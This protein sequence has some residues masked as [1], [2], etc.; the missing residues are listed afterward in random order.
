MY[1]YYYYLFFSPPS[2]V[3]LHANR[4]TIYLCQIFFFLYTPKIP[5]EYNVYFV[6]LSSV[7]S[8]YLVPIHVIIYI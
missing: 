2:T 6:R 3:D 4:Q 8:P 7:Q 5:K 1:Y